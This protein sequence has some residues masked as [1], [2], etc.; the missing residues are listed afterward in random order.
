MTPGRHTAVAAKAVLC[1]SAAMLLLRASA[2]AAGCDLE[3]GQDRAVARVIDSETLALDDG[4]DVR[5]IGVLGPR[6]FD[7][8]A[9]PGS[10]PAEASTRQAL[11]DLTLGRSVRLAYTGPRRDRYG[12]HLA[13][14][15]ITG[16]PD[17][18][19]AAEAP[20]TWLQ[21]LLLAGGLARA[22]VLP[23]QRTCVD[24]LLSQEAGARAASAG[25]WASAAYQPRHARETATLVR[26]AGTFQLVEGRV[27]RVGEGRQHFYLSFGGDRR[28][29]F[30][31]TFRRADRELLGTFGGD[32]G[33][34]AGRD[35]RV[36]GWIE[37][38][39]GGPVLDLS[40]GGLI[41]VLGGGDGSQAAAADPALSEPR[42]PAPRRRASRSRAA[43]P[44][45]P[46]EPAVPPAATK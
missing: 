33:A 18:A 34:L 13:H 32:A 27:A 31:V 15:F 20:A 19:A 7:T 21:G 35:V 36:R 22:S 39:N 8:G 44:V 1:V 5:L 40:S 17:P 29:E 41:E 43:A 25:M 10:W 11:A 3:A 23:G 14:V 16:R 9:A 38:R 12:R 30:E 37:L 45:P 46:L 6:A 24:E 2:A 4:S 28:R 26:L 42:T